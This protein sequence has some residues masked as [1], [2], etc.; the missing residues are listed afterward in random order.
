[1]RLGGTVIAC[2]AIGGADLVFISSAEAAPAVASRAARA[3]RA[4]ATSA[5]RAQILISAPTLALLGDRAG[6]LRERALITASG[7]PFKL[8][9]VRVE[10]IP[11]GT[12]AGAGA[13]AC[14]VDDRRLLYAGVA[15]LADPTIGAEP[16]AVRA[17]NALCLDATYG[18]PRFAFAARAAALAELCQRADDARAAGRT[19]VVL[20]APIALTVEAAVALAAAGWRLRAHPSLAETLAAYA[21]T[22]TPVPAAT[23]PP[24]G[25]LAPDELLLWP[26]TARAAAR[27]TR[28]AQPSFIW[29]AG[30]AGNPHARAAMGA[31]AGI[32][33]SNRPDHAGLRAY[34]DA[35]GAREVATVG[36]EAD[37]FASELRDAGLVAYALAAPS[38]IGLF[39]GAA[40]PEPRT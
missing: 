4:R 28:L 21:V 30:A 1:M 39:G 31:D 38:Q 7:R 17:A 6:P 5:P 13:L 22:G 29:L 36:A 27:L 40:S 9:A 37:A 11:S 12:L 8:G 25:P 2:D 10:V 3:M 18:H 15:R 24:A 14:E 19:P 26:E 20:V 34:V 23:P 32:A 33:Y 16:A 35:T